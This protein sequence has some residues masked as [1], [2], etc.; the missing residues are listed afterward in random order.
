MYNV[1]TR[2]TLVTELKRSKYYKQSLGLVSTID[3]NGAREFNDK[4]TFSHFYNT[5]YNTTIQR[6]GTIGDITF[7]IDYYIKE[8]IVALYL[9][10]EEFVFNYESTVV[11]QKGIDFFLGSLFKRLETENE[12]RVKEAEGKKIEVK[13]EANSEVI[14]QNPG[15]VT[16]DDLKAYLAKKNQNRMST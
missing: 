3:K 8:D 7:Y 9:N 1:V 15:N 5:Q 14:M 16:Y 10:T 4:D 11:K 12:E 2:P 13:K 6:Q